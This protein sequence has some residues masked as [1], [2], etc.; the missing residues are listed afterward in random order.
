MAKRDRSTTAREAR[1]SQAIV[2]TMIDVLNAM[3]AD[4]VAMAQFSHVK[5]VNLRGTLKNGAD[6]KKDWANELHPTKDG[7]RAVAAKIASA[8]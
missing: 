6:Y 5:Y 4:I 1:L 2:A 3:L 8:V 7:F